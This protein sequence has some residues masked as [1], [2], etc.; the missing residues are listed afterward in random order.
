MLVRQG[1]A[2][3]DSWH[4]AVQENAAAAILEEGGEG[5]AEEEPRTP[6]KT[7]APFA[8]ATPQSPMSPGFKF[9]E[10]DPEVERLWD[11][12]PQVERLWEAGDAASPGRVPFELV[13]GEPSLWVT[14]RASCVTLRVR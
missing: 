5:E 14:L 13:T 8:R 11:R 7:R 9:D 2:M 12:T 4:G 6:P 3:A 1:I 10:V